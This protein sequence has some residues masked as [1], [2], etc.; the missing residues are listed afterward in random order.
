MKEGHVVTHKDYQNK[1]FKIIRLEGTFA[2][3]RE[4]NPSRQALGELVLTKPI[5]DLKPF[6]EDV[7]QA[8]ARVVREASGN[9]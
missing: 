6:K 7:S 5:A 4:F 8:A 2:V 9:K 3:I 1:A